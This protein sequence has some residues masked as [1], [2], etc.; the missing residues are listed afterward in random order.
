MAKAKK[1]KY[2]VK[3]AHGDIVA[4]IEAKSET[5]AIKIYVDRQKELLSAE[6]TPHVSPYTHGTTKHDAHEMIIKKFKANGDLTYPDGSR[7]ETW[8]LSDAVVEDLVE[9]IEEMVN[10]W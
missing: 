2:D 3:N 1:E 5:Q 10:D 4:T 9:G 7:D 8:M 6:K